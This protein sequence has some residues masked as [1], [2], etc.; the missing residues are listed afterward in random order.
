MTTVLPVLRFALGITF[1]VAGALLLA[2]TGQ[3]RTLFVAW[4]IPL[5]G[6]AVL[7]IG[8]TDVVCGLLFAFGVLTRPVGLLLATIAVGTAMTAGRHGG[9]IYT[10]AAPILFLGCVFFA[11]RSGRVGG[12]APVRPPGVQ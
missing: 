10:L 11:W 4:Q 12:V 9:M 7:A 2:H 5:P 1:V 8:A 3:S 6:A